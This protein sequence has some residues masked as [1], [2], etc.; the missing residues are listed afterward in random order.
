MIEI[1]LVYP[2]CAAYRHASTFAQKVF[3]K[4]HGVHVEA[5]PY[6]FS[7]LSVGNDI[8]GTF[9]LYLASE[10][11]PLLIETFFPEIFSGVDRPLFG[12]L[13]T[14]AVDDIP[15]N[16]GINSFEAS[17]V[18][19]ALLIDH[20][21]TLGLDSVG[22]TTNKRVKRITDRLDLTIVAVAKADL[23]Y[24]DRD[25]QKNWERFFR[26]SQWG[27]TMD[28]TNTS[29]CRDVL[30]HYSDRLKMRQKLQR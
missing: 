21:H 6:V 27:Y 2:N 1:N 14:R 12:E 16:L 30:A 4:K 23:S 18:L 22:F 17:L 11:D 24:K 10:R 25:F 5:L 9:G 8:V 28:I 29:G 3:M 15:D 13:G 26:I 20:A 7:A 19:A